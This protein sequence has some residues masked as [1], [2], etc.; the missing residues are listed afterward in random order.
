MQLDEEQINTVISHIKNLD[1]YWAMHHKGISRSQKLAY[2]EVYRLLDS[3]VQMVHKTPEMLSLT[4]VSKI[5]DSPIY[6]VLSY[7]DFHY[8]ENIDITDMIKLAHMSRSSFFR[9]F[10]DITG[11]S[12]SHYLNRLRAVKAHELLSQT[13]LPLYEIAENTGFS[14]TAHMTRIFREIHG[15]SPSEYRRS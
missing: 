12:F 10:K 6:D 1:G 3:I 11:D 4:N 2:I 15:V 5:S 13:N 7:V 14:S 9:S 8:R